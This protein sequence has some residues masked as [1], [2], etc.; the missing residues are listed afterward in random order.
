M[1]MAV[2]FFEAVMIFLGGRKEGGNFLCVQ[3]INGNSDSYD[4]LKH[5]LKLHSVFSDYYQ[6][7]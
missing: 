7:I 4:K 1:R 3:T 5:I 6:D 2:T